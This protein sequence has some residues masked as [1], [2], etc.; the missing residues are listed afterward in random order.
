MFLEVAASLQQVEALVVV[1][2]LV[3]APS[4]MALVTLVLAV[5]HVLAD[6]SLEMGK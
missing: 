1:A 3:L 2:N 6:E 4:P 5:T